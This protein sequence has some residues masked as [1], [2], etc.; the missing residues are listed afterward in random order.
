M[1]IS[2]PKNGV[3]TC[4][5]SAP[6]RRG[7]DEMCYG[8][9]VACPF[10]VAVLVM[11][12]HGRSTPLPFKESFEWTWWKISFYWLNFGKG[13]SEGKGRPQKVPICRETKGKTGIVACMY[14]WTKWI[15]WHVLSN[16]KC[17]KVYISPDL[18][19]TLSKWTPLVF[20]NDFVLQLKWKQKREL[21]FWEKDTW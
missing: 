5:S 1:H 6:S 11:M 13:N 9:V 17:V 21:S 4:V 8:F 3:E 14:F 10:G 20:L 16:Y 15:H 7:G 19:S 12:L 2:L 18:R